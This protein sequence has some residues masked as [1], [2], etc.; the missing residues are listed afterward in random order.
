MVCESTAHIILAQILRLTR[1][2]ALVPL[3]VFMVRIGPAL[4]FH[5]VRRLH[6]RDVR[7]EVLSNTL[8]AQNCFQGTLYLAAGME[9]YTKQDF[10]W[11]DLVWIVS[12]KICGNYLGVND[13]KH[14]YKRK[15]LPLLCSMCHSNK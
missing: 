13:T 3:Y 5:L 2:K 14:A 10:F 8:Y 11:A 7:S 6:N 12:G 9:L 15:A 4:P 1:A